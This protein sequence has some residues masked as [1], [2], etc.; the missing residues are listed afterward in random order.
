MS[1]AAAYAPASMNHAPLRA[2]PIT[3]YAQLAGILRDRIVTG[4]WKPGDEI[5][6]LE[7]LVDEFAVARVTVRQAIQILVEEGLLSSQRGRRTCVTFDPAS[8][9]APLFSSTGSMDGEGDGNSYSIKV[10]SHQEFDQ[11]PT[12]FAGLGTPA[13]K[14]VR[15]RKIDG[16]NGTPYTVSD[17]YVALSLYQ[18]FP[19]GS[20]HTIKLSRLV[21]DNAR[22]PLTSAIERTSISVATYEDA[23]HLQVAVGSPVAHVMRAFFAPNRQLVYLGVLVYRAD[24]FAVERDVSY[25]LAVA[26][27]QADRTS[28]PRPLMHGAPATRP[29]GRGG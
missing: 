28:D 15:I 19:S 7:Q 1:L 12:Q 23:T 21:R 3:L 14:Y 9:D 4:L 27:G 20:E 24:R 6:T 29:G 10:L 13:G 2:G 5:P 26:P 25:A 16:L 18:R 17:N 11:L 22:P 8:V